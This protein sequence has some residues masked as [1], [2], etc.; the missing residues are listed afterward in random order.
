MFRI[1]SLDGGGIRGAFAAAFLHRLERQVGRPMTDYFDLIAGTSTGGI[2]ALALCLGE[3]AEKICN[4]YRNSGAAIF[5]PRTS[6]DLSRWQRLC[7]KAAKWKFRNLD[8]GAL[9]RSKYTADALRELLAAVFGARTLEDARAS[10][11]LIPAVNLTTGRTIVFKTPHQ[12]K[13][14]RDRYITAV[15]VALA[16]SAAPTFF[17]QARIGTG[18]AY[19][20]GGL[21]ANNP[22]MLAYAEAIKI[23]GIAKR[24]DLDP[25]FGLDEIHMISIGTGEP[26]YYAK[27]APGDDGLLWWADK[28]FEVAS[29]AASQGVDFQVRY[30]LGPER[31]QRIDFKMPSTPWRLDDVV[32]VPELLHYGE[33]AAID[34]YPSIKDRFLATKKAPYHPFPPD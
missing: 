27:P 32:A 5:A 17:P 19:A 25:T 30:V 2:I 28:L 24:D 6:D 23:H 9:Y 21:W 22:A 13:F 26:E 14:I 3:P 4:L 33:Q 18:G 15:D 34:N 29:G 31:Y 16:T 1:L 8:E 20:D 10:R 7:A 12:P 11:A